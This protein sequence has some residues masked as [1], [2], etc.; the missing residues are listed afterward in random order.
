M[1]LD[2]LGALGGV[3]KG[4][5]IGADQM[6]RQEA[7]DATL[8]AQKEAK[9]YRDDMLQIQK[10]AAQ[11][12]GD[13]HGVRMDAAKRLQEEQ[14]RAKTNQTL[15]SRIQSEY[16]DRPEYE[17]EQMYFD[18]A[19]KMGIL[20]P[21]E[22]RASKT[23]Y[24]GMVKKFG[25]EA[26][27]EAVLNG[28][29]AKLQKL[30]K[31]QGLGELAYDPQA[32]TFAVK[33]PQGSQVFKQRDLMQIHALNG[34]LEREQGRQQAGLSAL[35]TQAEIG[36]I[37]AEAGRAN[38]QY[39]DEVVHNPDG[40]VTIV[41]G[42]SGRRSGGGNGG[43]RAAPGAT[44]GQPAARDGLGFKDQKDLQAWIAATIPD[45]GV[46]F[47]DASGADV[48]VGKAELL[49]D[50]ESAFEQLMGANAERGLAPHIARDIALNVALAK[51]GR[52]GDGQYVPVPQLNAETGQ[53]ENVVR[54]GDKIVA[55]LPSAVVEPTPEQKFEQ[56]T[57]YAS[58]LVD[59]FGN[60]LAEVARD[61]QGRE[62]LM[63]GLRN[64]AVMQALGQKLGIPNLDRTLELLYAHTSLGD[65]ILP[66]ERLRQARAEVLKTRDAKA[67]SARG[68]SA[69][70]EF[71]RVFN[72][73]T[74]SAQQAATMRAGA[75]Q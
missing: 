39:Q 24:D 47:K 45:D 67:K 41:P 11:R 59:R 28:N 16:G 29:P 32:G 57:A 3:G 75:N 35:K 60:K 31:D 55:R 46:A 19:L 49:R 20:K 33:T 15:Y 72:L 61:P 56:E 63:T 34:V 62:A 44:G 13:V 10:D 17:R 74:D 43:S 8:A 58:K 42:G 18:N 53:W 66:D 70:S 7:H 12:A 40:S 23:A 9:A 69:P 73:I 27:D 5:M 37:N 30:F 14:E 64:P 68:N 21:E 50:T 4:V 2:F 26:F 52:A 1:A 54:S 48:T 38:R 25:V 6:R 22:L 36:K 51:R 65:V 71:S